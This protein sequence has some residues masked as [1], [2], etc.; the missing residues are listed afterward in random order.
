MTGTAD[1]PSVVKVQ[2]LCTQ[3]LQNSNH[4]FLGFA[5]FN[6][7]CASRS[8]PDGLLYIPIFV[9]METKV[10]GCP[11]P[12]SSTKQNQGSDLLQNHWEDKMLGNI[13][14]SSSKTS[15]EVSVKITGRV[16]GLVCL[17]ENRMD[18]R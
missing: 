5:A 12:S 11:G 16:D 2:Q 7:D 8:G 1:V 9:F 17:T 3:T 6:S 10:D 14:G 18:T 15:Y 4:K 13:V